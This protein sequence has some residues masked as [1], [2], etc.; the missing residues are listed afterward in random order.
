MLII[1]WKSRKQLCDGCMS[2]AQK[3]QQSV[4]TLAG[5][6]AKMMAFAGLTHTH[7]THTLAHTHTQPGL[8]LRNA[9]RAINHI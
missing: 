8:R 1:I 7:T 2:V 9:T 3:R 4:N 5:A 6:P